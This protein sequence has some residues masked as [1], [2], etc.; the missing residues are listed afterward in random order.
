M[1]C[2]LKI[3]AQRPHTPA[4]AAHSPTAAAIPPESPK[5]IPIPRPVQPQAILRPWVKGVL[6]VPRKIFPEHGPDKASPNYLASTTPEPLP[7]NVDRHRDPRT[8]DFASYKAR[9]AE[10]RR[11]NLRESLIE[12]RFRKERT[13]SV[14]AAKSRKK[15]AFNRARREAPQ[16]EDERLT[17]A[18][19]LQSDIPRRH[20]ILP[21]PDREARLAAKRENVARHTVAKEEERRDMLHTL[22]INAGTFITTG[23]QLDQVVDRVFDNVEQFTN[24]EKRGQNIW[25]LG[26]PE[27]VEEMLGG[28]ASGVRVNRPKALD[29]ALV[30]RK[31]LHDHRMTRIGEELT[32]GKA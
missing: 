31:E 21:D 25:N 7:H 5:F 15:Q 19:V 12:L 16:R 2:R 30:S 10:N 18:T 29:N 8:A 28:K 27:T 1:W 32:G 23:S 3:R 13:D 11:N 9:Q 6:P 4:T 14:V 17:N 24:D 20:T 26:F 22:Y